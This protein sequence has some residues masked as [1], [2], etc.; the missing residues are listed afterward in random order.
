MFSNIFLK[1]VINIALC[2][3]MF[4]LRIEFYSFKLYCIHKSLPY[5]V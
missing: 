3:E 4:N 2:R 5:C 1:F